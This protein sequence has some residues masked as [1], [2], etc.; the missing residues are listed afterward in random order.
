MREP[1]LEVI[2]CDLDRFDVGAQEELR[3]RALRFL[4]ESLGER[5]VVHGRVRL[6][7]DCA[8]AADVRLESSHVLRRQQCELVFAHPVREAP[9]PILL[10]MGQLIGTGRDLERAD[11]Q[12]RQAAFG[13][14]RLP[15]S[16][17]DLG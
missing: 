11:G 14:E 2:L 7:P 4:P 9:V 13:R 1:D 8:V 10:E 5:L 12:P 15:H 6:R 3:P 16:V 17:R